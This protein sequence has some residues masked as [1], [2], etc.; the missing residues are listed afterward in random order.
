[1]TN[2]GQNPGCGWCDQCKADYIR[3][4]YI[5]AEQCRIRDILIERGCASEYA[6]RAAGRFIRIETIKQIMWD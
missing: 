4:G 1:M 3:E 6:N 5:D 2:C